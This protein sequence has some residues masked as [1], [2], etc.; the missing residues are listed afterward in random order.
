VW[1]IK[2]FYW[3][4]VMLFCVGLVAVADHIRYDYFN[5]KLVCVPV[6]WKFDISRSK[7]DGTV[8]SLSSD[9]SSSRV[10]GYGRKCRH[11][12]WST[13]TSSASSHTMLTCFRFS[14]NSVPESRSSRGILKHYLHRSCFDIRWIH[15]SLI[16]PE[17]AIKV[18]MQ[19]EVA[20]FITWF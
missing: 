14:Q 4:L 13:A 10:T 7:H 1:L 8:F 3:C 2:N 17:S 15:P 11:H 19:Q 5:R 6:G 18:L 9:S 16:G 20:H 12:D